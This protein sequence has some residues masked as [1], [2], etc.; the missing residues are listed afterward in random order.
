MKEVLLSCLLI[1]VIGSC[2][3][4]QDNSPV[5]VR[6]YVDTTVF[7]RLRNW[8]LYVDSMR[9]GK[10]PY[11]PVEPT[12]YASPAND[13]AKSLDFTIQPGFHKIL[14]VS[15]D[16]AYSWGYDLH[17]SGGGCTRISPK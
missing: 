11:T 15:L 1:L 6:G 3:K 2:S 17:A 16:T 14:F 5:T 12:C 4:K 7:K 8:D 13:S 9:I 10:L